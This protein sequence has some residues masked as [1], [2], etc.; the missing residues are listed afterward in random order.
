[1]Q[2][3]V[4]REYL[5]SHFVDEAVAKYL[6]V[7]CAAALWCQPYEEFW[8]LNGTGSNGKT[9]MM[10]FLRQVFGDYFAEINHT[11]LTRPLQGGEGASPFIAAL[12]GVRLVN[13]AEPGEC[14]TIE[15]Q[16][17]KR[18][19]GQERLV[20]RRLYGEPE[21]IPVNYKLFMSAND[22]PD[23]SSAGESVQRR[24][25]LVNFEMTFCDKPE[26]PRQKQAASYIND[27]WRKRYA[28]ALLWMLATQQLPTTRNIPAPQSIMDASKHH[29]DTA[30]ADLQLFIDS[31]CTL[32][33]RTRA[34]TM[35]AF[36]EAA[37]QFLK[38]Q[39]KR[40]VS[41]A[42]FKNAMG[43]LGY[44]EVSESVD[45]KHIRAW[46]IGTEYLCLGWS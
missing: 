43:Q 20:A 17:L 13:T 30:L 38:H 26:G 46:R 36:R 14:D 37:M 23:I 33:D 5:R 9:L 28:P 18:M 4:V 31:R 1:V 21:Y 25:R 7:V 11:V 42:A 24:F 22:A 8:L 40:K 12:R 27:E 35:M 15:A 44:A 10:S 19:A 32:T 6:V 16:Q 41:V 39:R 29:V 2:I 3:E 45:G 34:T